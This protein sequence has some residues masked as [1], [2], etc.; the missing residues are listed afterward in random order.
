MKKYT[1]KQH[2]I[3]GLL[4]LVVVVFVLSAGATAYVLFASP[5]GLTTQK[6]TPSK[7]FADFGLDTPVPTEAPLSKSTLTTAIKSDLD[8]TVFADFDKDMAQLD[9]MINEL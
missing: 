8:G 6:A 5:G 2:G 3:S 9:Q 4:L 7:R 1:N